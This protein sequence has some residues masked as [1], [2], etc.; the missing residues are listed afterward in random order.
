MLCNVETGKIVVS[1][2]IRPA[3][4]SPA[5]RIFLPTTLPPFPNDDSSGGGPGAPKIDA[6]ADSPDNVFM[7]EVRPHI[8][9]RQQIF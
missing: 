9:F 5:A 7:E 8:D 4:P 3:S 6:K 2:D 1:K